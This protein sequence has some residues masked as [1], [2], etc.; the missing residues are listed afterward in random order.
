MGERFQ[1]DTDAFLDAMRAERGASPHTLR[2]YRGDLEQLKAWLEET[3]R[4]ALAPSDLSHKVLRLWL[5]A[6]V[7]R[8]Q[9]STLSR[10]VSCLRAFYA[11]LVRRGRARE[12]P[13]E[14]L[15]LP[16]V[17]QDLRNFLNVDEAFALVAPTSRVDPIG[18]RDLAMWEVLY[19]SGLRV[20]E[21][22]GLDLAS[23][24]LDAGWVRVLGKGS[25][26]RD[27]PLTEPA[28]DAI[29]AYLAARRELVAKAPTPPQAL[30]LNYEGG[31]I[32]D[33]SVR[34]LLKQDLIRKG[35]NTDVSPH[36]LRH[37]FA[38]HQLDTNADL[39]GIQELLGH[40]SLSTTQRY[41]HVALGTLMEAYDQAHPR[42]RRA[43]AAPGDD[44][45]S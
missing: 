19:G 21:L 33:R 30:F 27:V 2:A 41:T 37:S 38:T 17:K 25:K 13:A 15:R 16:K 44:D 9:A 8:C 23:L 6:M 7:E 29:R 34:R 31:R 18:L 42:A 22:V 11:W 1:H 45:A 43:G 5:G 20:S 14:L 3:G 28:I 4:G 12:N 24:D 35:V 36:G 39:R 10:R 40:A 26:E 32:T